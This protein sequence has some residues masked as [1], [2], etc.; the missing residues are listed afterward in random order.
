MS[1][2]GRNVESS[3]FFDAIQ[4]HVLLRGTPDSEKKGPCSNPAKAVLSVIAALCRLMQHS[5]RA[6]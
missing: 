4:P 3:A 6:R 1:C 5:R 2:K